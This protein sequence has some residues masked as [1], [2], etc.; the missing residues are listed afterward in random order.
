MTAVTEA[1]LVEQRQA[2]RRRL[3]A[4]RLVIEH[5]LGPTP[6]VDSSYP[7]SMTMRFLNQGPTL[8]THLFVELATLLIGARFIKPIMVA[9]AV[10]KIVRSASTEKCSTSN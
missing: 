7:R 8:S 3:Q 6:R 1:S 2:L 10:A 9:V 5:R 4:Q